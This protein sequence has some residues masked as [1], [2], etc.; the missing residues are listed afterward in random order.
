MHVLIRVPAAALSLILA[1]GATPAAAAPAPLRWE[2]VGYDAENTY[3]NPHENVITAATVGRL[4]KKWSVVLRKGDSC[5][6]FGAPVIAGGRIFVGD[7]AG[8]SAYSATTGAKKWSFDWDEFGEGNPP[9]MAVIGGLLVAGYN[10]CYSMSDPNSQVIALDVATGARRWAGGS[11]LVGGLVMDKGVILASDTDI[12][13]DTQTV[14]YRVRDGKKLWSVENRRAAGVSAD[15]TVPAYTTD[16]EGVRAGEMVAFDITSGA[17][18]WTRKGYLSADAASPG[19]DTFY[20]PDA[21]D[22][23]A[24]V[25]VKDGAVRW[26][27]PPPGQSYAPIATDGARV[28][29]SSDD[30]VTAF[31]ARTGKKAWSRKLA[32]FA[33]QPLVAGGLVYAGDVALDAERG[34]VIDDVPAFEGDVVVTGGVLYQ[35]NEGVLTAYAIR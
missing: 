29:R 9:R 35:A 30:T 22:K 12:Y 28:Y 21:K 6:G 18:R 5:A 32:S 13:G 27:A 3:F 16:D 10:D 2:H 34:K 8:I 24:A 1:A 4:A 11:P 20:G 31:N 19:A 17:V 26:T 14:A 23:L 33:G 7:Q 25:S 15:G